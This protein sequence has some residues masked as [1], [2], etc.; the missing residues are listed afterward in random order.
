MK[1]GRS[2]RHQSHGHGHASAATTLPP[3][4]PPSQPSQTRPKAEPEVAR[5]IPLPDLSEPLVES[6]APVALSRQ[7]RRQERRAQAKQ[8]RRTGTPVQSRTLSSTSGDP[9]SAPSAVQEA[10]IAP[11]PRDRSLAIRRNGVLQIG[12]WLRGL[13]SRK[14]RSRRV[15]PDQAVQQ[16]QAMRVELAHM[17]RTLER[18]LGGA[19]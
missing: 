15:S 18:M 16:I 5:A 9:D 6:P 8:L 17:Q 2:R 13:L 1:N 11:L 3:R 4:R 19:G 12:E 14:P 10:D 7:V